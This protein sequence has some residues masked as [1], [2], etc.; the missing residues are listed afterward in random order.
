MRYQLQA[1]VIVSIMIVSVATIIYFA[2]NLNAPTNETAK[3]TCIKVDGKYIDTICMDTPK[4]PITCKEEIIDAN[5]N[6]VCSDTP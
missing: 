1:M 4:Y 3:R 2:Y 6:V 5:A